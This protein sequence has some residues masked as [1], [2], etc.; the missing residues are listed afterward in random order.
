MGGGILG[1]P[2]WGGVFGESEVG[3]WVGFGVDGG[4][5]KTV[6]LPA[7]PIIG[8]GVVDSFVLVE[9]SIAKKKKKCR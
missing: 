2:V 9:A 6:Y 4:V 3:F 8:G 1:D 5:R 7:L